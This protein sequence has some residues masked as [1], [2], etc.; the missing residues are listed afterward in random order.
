MLHHSAEEHG[1]LNVTRV[2]V[3]TFIQ[4]GSVRTLLL[5]EDPKTSTAL[6]QVKWAPIAC[7]DWSCEVKHNRT[8]YILESI[9]KV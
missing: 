5:F 8:Q 1:A 9:A 7:K 2:G 6:K 4:L 3:N